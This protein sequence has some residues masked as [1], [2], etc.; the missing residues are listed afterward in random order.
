MT[1][2]PGRARLATKPAPTGSPVFAITIGM[3]AVAFFAANAAVPRCH[4]QINLETNQVRRK[5]RQALRLLLGKSVLDGDILSLNPPKL[6]QLLPER[7]PRGPPYRKQ[8]LD[9]GNLCGR[10]FPAAARRRTS[11]AQRAWRKG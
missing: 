1:L 5:L 3:V 8:C 2:P 9:R 6:A 10:F 4:N 7:A 11:K